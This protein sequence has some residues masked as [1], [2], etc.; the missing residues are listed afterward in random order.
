MIN[1]FLHHL[2]ACKV[3]LSFCHIPHF[4]DFVTGFFTRYHGNG[5]KSHSLY[6]V[7]TNALLFCLQRSSRK[8]Q[9][10]CVSPLQSH[11]LLLPQCISSAYPIMHFVTSWQ[12]TPSWKFDELTE[13]EKL[14]FLYKNSLILFSKIALNDS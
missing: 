12:G 4:F 14:P 10:F 1:L 11:W 8:N 5:K 6:F 7:I 9:L 3:K 2:N 13:V